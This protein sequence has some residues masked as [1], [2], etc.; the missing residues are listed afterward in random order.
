MLPKLQ[1]RYCFINTTILS[2]TYAPLISLLLVLVSITGGLVPVFQ[3]K[4]SARFF[5]LALEAAGT[6]L[7]P[8]EP[9]KQAA[10]G[11]TALSDLVAILINVVGVMAY[12]AIAAKWAVLVIFA[13]T[14][15]LIY[16]SVKG[17]RANYQVNREMSLIERKYNYLREILLDRDYV[18]ERTMFGYSKKLNTEAYKEYEKTYKIRVK[19]AILWHTKTKFGSILNACSGLAVILILLKPTLSGSISIGLFIAVI[20]GVFSLTGYLSWGLSNNIDVLFHT[21][22]FTKDLQELMSFSE[23]P[24]ALTEPESMDIVESIEFINVSFCYPGTEQYILRGLSFK[25][26]KGRHYAF[27]GA[28]GAGKTT[29]VKLLTGLYRNYTGQILIN[30]RDLYS[31]TEPQRKGLWAVVYQDFARYSFTVR[32]NC[33]IGDIASLDSP[34]A[35]A[36]V[37]SAFSLLELDDFLAALPMGLNTPLP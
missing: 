33:A 36:R 21:G 20:N 28:N 16:F 26:E 22:E 35:A 7:V 31:Y 10:Q 14:V 17:G 29:T 18:D 27:V 1:K 15:P 9:E 13:F 37:D 3:I 11:L 8:K 2:F 5:E 6:G 23:T 12:V 24:E 32:E 25:L 4:V 30:G 34:E 19:T